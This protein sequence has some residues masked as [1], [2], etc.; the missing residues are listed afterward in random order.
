MLY[1]YF[2]QK[3][4]ELENKEIETYFCLLKRTGKSG[5]MLE[6]LRITSGQKRMSNALE[7]MNSIIKNIEVDN[8]IKNKLHCKDCE[9][10]FTNHCEK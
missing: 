6:F 9:Y 7:F 2:C 5:K 3:R 1:K 4:M 10:H 8:F